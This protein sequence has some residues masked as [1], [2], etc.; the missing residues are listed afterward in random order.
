MSL[1]HILL[2]LFPNKVMKCAR[3]ESG[4]STSLFSFI[5]FHIFFCFAL[6]LYAAAHE[7]CVG[8]H[9]C[10][11]FC[12][13]AYFPLIMF[14]GTIASLCGCR[15]SSSPFVSLC[16]VPMAYLKT[17]QG[18]KTTTKKRT[19]TLTIAN[20]KRKTKRVA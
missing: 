3:T 7:L 9:M 20:G 5:S 13:F 2:E 15:Y 11:G 18:T 17:E 16:I 19:H 10:S 8:T 6:L 4:L 12:L 14:Y 1:I